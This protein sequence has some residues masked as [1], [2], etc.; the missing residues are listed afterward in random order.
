MLTRPALTQWR[1]YIYP[2]VVEFIDDAVEFYNQ[3]RLNK[4]QMTF[5]DLLLRATA[6]LRDSP[7]VRRYFGTR[8]EIL[9]VDEFQD[10]DPI[11]AEML[12]YLTGADTEGTDWQRLEP[13]PGSL[14]I[15]GDEKQSI[16]RFRRADVATFRLA[17]A[18]LEVAAG[19]TEQLNTSFRSLGNLCTWINGTFFESWA[20]PDHMLLM[21]N[22]H[23]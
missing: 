18:Q 11:Q 8:Y 5:G 19:S 23:E 10:T 9:F 21:N 1:Q 14:F 7:Q 22:R 3:Q 17:A 20:L 6:L 12:F 16:Y 13:R 4:G 2:H 15:V